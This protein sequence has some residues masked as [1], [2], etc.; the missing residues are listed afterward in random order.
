[1]GVLLFVVLALEIGHDLSADWGISLGCPRDVIF[2]GAGAGHAF[3]G[4]PCLPFGFGD[5]FPD[6]GFLGFAVSD[7]GLF[8]VGIEL[9]FE[10][11]GEW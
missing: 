6:G 9:Q 7:C 5:H 11:V 4:V 8:V 2:H 3:E 1:M 10:F